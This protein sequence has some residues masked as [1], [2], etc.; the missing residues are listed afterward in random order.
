MRRLAGD[1]EQA[2]A[3]ALFDPHDAAA[4]AMGDAVIDPAQRDDGALREGRGL[5][6]VVEPRSDPSAVFLGK[7]PRLL[8]AAARRHGEHDVTRDRID[9]QRVAL[10][11]P[12]PAHPHQTDLTLAY[13]ADR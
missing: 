7:F 10:R 13:D 5:R 11:L 6:Q 8:K 1:A 2:F 3:L 4:T 9:A 12:V